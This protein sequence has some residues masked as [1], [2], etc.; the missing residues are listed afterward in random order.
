MVNSW[1]MAGYSGTENWTGGT[2]S[3]LSHK[4]SWALIS[5]SPRRGELFP[6][7]LHGALMSSIQTLGRIWLTKSVFQIIRKISVWPAQYA[8]PLATY[9]CAILSFFDFNILCQLP[10]LKER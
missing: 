6:Y 8:L 10:R 5:V 3:C 7:S 2:H 9:N 4:L 1:L